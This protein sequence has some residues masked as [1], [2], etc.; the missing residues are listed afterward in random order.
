MRLYMD[1][2]VLAVFTYFKNIESNRY[3]SVSELIEICRNR[4]MEIVVSFYALHEL[5]LLPFDHFD[6]KTARTIG[7]K[8]V[9]EI[10]K[11]DGVELIELL[12]R[13]NRLLYQERFR[14]NDRTDIPH[15][16]SAFVEGCDSIIT[17]DTHFDQI[18]HLISVSTPENFVASIR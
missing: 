5:F 6:E 11:I 9:T 12:S 15:A 10:L 3:K 8:F 7:K 14:M 17:Y 13:D 18:S 16:I 4:E 1:T 2:S